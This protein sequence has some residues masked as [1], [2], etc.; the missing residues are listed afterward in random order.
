MNHDDE[1][2]QTLSVPAEVLLSAP[3]GTWHDVGQG[4][5]VRALA[6]DTL[7]TVHV[8]RLEQGPPA[9]VDPAAAVIVFMRETLRVPVHAWQA[10]M[11][12]R[13]FRNPPAIECGRR[14][15]GVLLCRPRAGC[16]DCPLRE[17]TV[18]VDAS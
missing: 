13:L 5:Q 1:Q 17:L 10:L 18:P 9:G 8:R 6:T 7:G 12:R 14:S 15:D 3:F 11:I 16:D 2:G 4:W